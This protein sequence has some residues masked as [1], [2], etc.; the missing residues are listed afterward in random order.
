[1]KI[2]VLSDIHANI[3]AFR[4]VME[5]EKEYDILCFAGD[6][7][8]YGTEPS[9]VIE[10]L[11]SAP[12]ALLVQGNHDLH[13]VNAWQ[14]EDFRNMPVK[15][16]KWIHY[17]LERMSGE[18]VDYLKNLP[19]HRYFEADGWVYLIQH[20]YKSGS[21]DV[22][23]NR[24][25]FDRYWKEHMPKAYWDAPNR[26]MI[27]GHSHRQCIHVLGEGM[28]W[29]NPGSVS[30]RRPDDP[31]KTA[32]YMVIEGGAITMRQIPYDRRPLYEEALCQ[33]KGGRM[34]DTE[35][36]DFM[37][38]FGNAVSSRDELPVIGK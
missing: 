34:M 18:Q 27:F 10:S 2:L 13:A 36:Q 24:S 19:L 35:I 20:Q 8:D 4:G 7:V 37:F 16:Y 5:R 22:I 1:M 17:N 15:K 9:Q 31:D 26:R 3:Q 32:H 14:E 23:E 12:R 38:F 30:Y 6:M 28:E 33:L 11:R 25:Q 29:L 21:Y